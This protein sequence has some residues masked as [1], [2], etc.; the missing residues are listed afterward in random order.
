MRSYLKGKQK[1]EKK[2]KQALRF[3]KSQAQ[4]P[5][6]STYLLT[7]STRHEHGAQTCTQA[8]HLKNKYTIFN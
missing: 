4:L 2:G 8:K 6:P 5:A 3:H 7:L 1:K